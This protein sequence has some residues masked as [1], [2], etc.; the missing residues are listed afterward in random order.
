MEF[1]Y[2][3]YKHIGVEFCLDK[4]IM[5][6]T[7]EDTFSPAG[8]LTRGQL[9]TMLYRYE[10]SP[11]VTGSSSFTDL[12]EDW[13][14]PAIAWA[15]SVGIVNGTSEDTFSPYDP[16]TGEQLATI[17]YRYAKSKGY[18]TTID[19]PDEPLIP[20]ERES[21]SEYAYDPIRWC[22]EKSIVDFYGSSADVVNGITG[23]QKGVKRFDTAYY[24]Y[25]LYQLSG[26]TY[27]PN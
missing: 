17:F 2:L 7:G 1:D 25:R 26:E 8:V 20:A 3:N 15:A 6:G 21:I 11:A 23:A 22:L 12:W 19:N 24:F 13:Y 27:T 14:K 9:A 4:G 10:G 5:N 18:D 16:I